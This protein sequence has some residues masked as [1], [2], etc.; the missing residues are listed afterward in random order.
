MH[1]I[2]RRGWEIP[3]RLATPEAVF[4]NRRAFLG[5]AAGAAAL[6]L[7][8]SAASA[9]RVADLPDPTADLYPAKRNE[10]FPLYR[11]LP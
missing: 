5:S 11:P 6:A 3:E 10:K 1:V 2:H 4:L 7:S 9:Q 8:P